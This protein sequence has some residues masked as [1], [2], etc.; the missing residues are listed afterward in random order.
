VRIWSSEREIS[1]NEEKAKYHRQALGLISDLLRYANLF[2]PVV[3]NFCLN[4]KGLSVNKPVRGRTPRGAGLIWS[5]QLSKTAGVVEGFA[6]EARPK[7]AKS[8][9][10]AQRFYLRTSPCI[11]KRG[12]R[13]AGTAGGLKLR[14]RSP[15]L[16][17]VSAI[18]SG[19]SP[20]RK[21]H[22]TKTVGRQ[23]CG[24]GEK[25][26]DRNAGSLDR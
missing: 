11:R 8:R 17:E 22:Q 12:V 6:I 10:R 18:Q 9:M 15:L 19:T 13:V 16:P 2:F 3:K 21:R 26:S 24:G 23:G 4:T 25:I 7:Q 1:G 14:I 20:P 5:Q